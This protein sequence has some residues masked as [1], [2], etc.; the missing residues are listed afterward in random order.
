MLCP[1]PTPGPLRLF[2]AAVSKFF[3]DTRDGPCIRVS[4][5]LGSWQSAYRGHPGPRDRHAGWGQ[6]CGPSAVRFGSRRQLQTDRAGAAL[7]VGREPRGVA[8]THTPGVSR[9]VRVGK[10]DGTGLSLGLSSD[11]WQRAMQARGASTRRIL[12]EGAPGGHTAQ[13]E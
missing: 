8:V 2:P 3:V 4:L 5:R 7:G 9:V 6:A 13:P 10:S 11:P 1:S 12:E